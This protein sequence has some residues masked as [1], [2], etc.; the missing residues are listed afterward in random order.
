SKFVFLVRLGLAL[1]RLGGIWP[2]ASPRRPFAFGGRP[3]GQMA[4]WVRSN[5]VGPSLCAGAPRR[6]VSRK[7][8]RGAL[9]EGRAPQGCGLGNRRWRA[10]VAARERGAG[11]QL[12][13]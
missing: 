11:H 4:T 7:P 2:E 10:R 9:P 13:L 6:H 1:I 12:D 5:Y 8:R 3:R